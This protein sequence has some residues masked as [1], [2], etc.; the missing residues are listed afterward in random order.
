MRIFYA[1]L[2]FLN[3]STENSLLKEFRKL[4]NLAIVKYFNLVFYFALQESSHSEKVKW[5]LPP[6]G[7]NTSCL[8]DYK[9]WPSVTK[10]FPREPSHWKF[11][12]ACM[13][14]FTSVRAKGMTSLPLLKCFLCLTLALKGNTCDRVIYP[15]RKNI[16]R[17]L[18]EEGMGFEDLP[19]HLPLFFFSFYY[20]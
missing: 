13:S 9:A 11:P 3:V 1:I 15:E 6:L 10:N 17:A 20:M 14:A 18:V 5:F 7:P 2:L 12:I 16:V 4:L 8:W 19:P